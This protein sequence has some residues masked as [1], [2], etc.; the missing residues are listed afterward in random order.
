MAYYTEFRFLDTL[1][2]N[3]STIAHR[4]MP[5]MG[6]GGA[7]H[8]KGDGRY[9]LSRQP[10]VVMFSGL[11]LSS[12]VPLGLPGDFELFAL[13]GFRSG[14]AL[15]TIRFRFQPRGGEPYEVDMPVYVRRPR[16]GG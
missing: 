11:P 10:D 8:E 13:P 3:D 15:E 6:R 1:G 5:R 4:R 7:G 2:L 9:V 12:A 16:Q 14:Y